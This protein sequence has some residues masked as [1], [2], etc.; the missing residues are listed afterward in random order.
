MWSFYWIFFNFFSHDILRIGF[1]PLGWKHC[2]P[3][4]Q[5]QSSNNYTLKFAQDGTFQITVFSDLHFAEGMLSDS[6]SNSTA[7]NI[8]FLP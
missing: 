6:R 2:P 1:G 7:S 4:T 3:L 8:K 5:S